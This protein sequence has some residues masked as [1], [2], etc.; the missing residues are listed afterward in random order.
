MLPLGPFTKYRI[1]Q[2]RRTYEVPQDFMEPVVNYL[3]YGFHP[4]SFFTA[5]LANDCWAAAAHSHPANSIVAL[6]N[7]VS[8]L[9]NEVPRES[10]GNYENVEFWCKL[11][12]AKRRDVLK[13]HRLMFE[14]DYETFLILKHG[15]RVDPSIA[16][17]VPELNR[18]Y[19]DN[20]F[21]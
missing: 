19:L 14:E 21:G 17:Q 3:F 16:D 12:D 10:V 4:G 8:L 1:E 13:K 20:D 15:V 2:L 18:F 6:K 7:L 5:V 11:P 9:R